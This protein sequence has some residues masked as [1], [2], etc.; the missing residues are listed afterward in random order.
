[1]ALLCYKTA[2]QNTSFALLYHISSILSSSGI[3]ERVA[4][5]IKA[6]DQNRLIPEPFRH[7]G[8]QKPKTKEPA[9]N[10]AGSR[11]AL[12]VEIT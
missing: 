8:N 11:F 10:S 4:D 9:E 3:V 5:K 7:T 6:G 1:M 12:K 2:V